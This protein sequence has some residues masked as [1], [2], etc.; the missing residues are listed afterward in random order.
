[1]QE[2]QVDVD[3][4]ICLNISRKNDLK[5]QEGEILSSNNNLMYIPPYRLEKKGLEDLEVNSH[6][7]QKL[8]WHKLYKSINGIINKLNTS[9]IESML[10]DIFKL[11]I[12]RGRG[13]LVRCIIRFQLASP[14]FTA[15]Y[16]S[17]CAVLNSYIP[18]IGSLL[19]HLLVQQFRESYSGNDKLVCIGTLKFLAHLVNQK[20]FHELIALEICSI[21]LEKATEDSIET[22]IN[23]VL[24]C[25]QTLLDVCPKGLDTIMDRFRVLFCDKNIHKRI[26]YI[27]EKLFKERRTNFKNYPAVSDDLDLVEED[28]Q[29]THLIDLLEDE[30][31]IQE[32]L[33]RFIPVDPDI[34]AEEERK[35]AEL[36]LDILGSEEED[37][38]QDSEAEER[39][40]ASE[41][42][43]SNQFV[44][45]VDYSEQELVILRKNI[46]LCIMNSLGFEE[47]VHR[48]LKLNIRPGGKMEVCIMLVDCCSMERTYQKFFALVGERLC[49]VKKEY[50][51]AFAEL[52]GRQYDTVHRLETNKLR[53]VSKF[54]AYLLSTDA[55]PWQILSCITLS[56]SDT[57][58]SSRIFIKILFQELCEYMGLDSL[59]AKLKL[60]SVSPYTEGIFPNDHNISNIRFSI[61]FFTAIGLAALTHDLR[62][63][64]KEYEESQAIK[65]NELED[66]D[67]NCNNNDLYQY[68]KEEEEKKFNSNVEQ[69]AKNMEA[70]GIKDLDSHSS[71]TRNHDSD[72]KKSENSCK[73]SLEYKEYG[74][75]ED[76]SYLPGC[77]HS[78]R[79]LPNKKSSRASS[80]LY[81]HMEH[82]KFK[83]KRCRNFEKKLT[84]INRDIDTS[85][86]CYRMSSSSP[87]GKFWKHKRSRCRSLSR[88][89]ST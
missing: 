74:S 26:K 75:F 22:C 73:I 42:K 38:R 2:L 46:Y 23:F 60:P 7:Y 62:I 11:N 40:E 43:E 27:I 88:E 4:N 9:N 85:T 64:L 48:L 84:G 86:S 65:I 6:E 61:N 44:K 35:W 68:N 32:N 28:D 56:E 36:K 29:V 87:R 14:H 8:M 76:N 24:E 77:S 79:N 59:D 18:D 55:I 25:G 58:S 71:Y 72:L 49:K 57:T 20:V 37:K 82:G 12:V 45:I 89:F 66:D 69:K 67:E 21:L 63:L 19:L 83:K 70:V 53:H 31:K 51:E 47:C 5:A 1:M 41:H 33:N 39:L 52:F 10:K 50:E 16:S 3:N 34:F 54:F 80:P 15:V 13:L 81:Q 30:I 17:F 78:L